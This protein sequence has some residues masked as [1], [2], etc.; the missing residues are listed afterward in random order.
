MMSQNSITVTI[1]ILDPVYPP[2]TPE[3]IEWVRDLMARQGNFAK[4]NISNR[5]IVEI[6]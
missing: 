2:F 3:K 5:D 1:N 4:S 6:K